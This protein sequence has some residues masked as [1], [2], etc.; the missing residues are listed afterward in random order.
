VK[1]IGKPCAGKSQARFDEGG[2][3]ETSPLLYG[4]LQRYGMVRQ[5]WQETQVTMVVGAREMEDW[6]GKI[7]QKSSQSGC[8]SEK[9]QR[10]L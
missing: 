10:I 7:M 4:L 9:H 5:S 6:Y 8:N 3:G 2:Q 1:N